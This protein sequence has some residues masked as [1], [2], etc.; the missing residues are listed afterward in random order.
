[1]AYVKKG[2]RPIKT[3][4]ERMAGKWKYNPVNGCWEWRRNFNIAGYGMIWMK[5]DKGADRSER[6]H[7]LSWVAWRGPIPAGMAILHRCDNRRCVNPDHLFLGTRADNNRDCVAKGRKAVGEKHPA[8][9]LTLAEV[10]AIRDAL[11]TGISQVHLARQYKIDASV[12]SR[13]KSGT[14]WNKECVL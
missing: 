12:I 14:A 11:N 7:R 13:I 5:G 10:S 1:M 3:S 6:A 9:K 4:E 2:P 8:A